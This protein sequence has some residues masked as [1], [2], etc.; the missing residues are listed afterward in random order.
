MHWQ[1]ALLQLPQSPAASSV[2][3]RASP[4]SD[5]LFP[6]RHFRA[7]V[8][9]LL[10]ATVPAA[11]HASESAVF[12]MAE[13]ASPGI[14]SVDGIELVSVHGTGTVSASPSLAEVR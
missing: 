13:P 8:R 4:A 10:L 14:A 11:A 12:R 5:T 6:E 9:T 7:A 1:V 2:V 3:P